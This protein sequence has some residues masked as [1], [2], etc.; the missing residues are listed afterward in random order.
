MPQSFLNNALHNAEVKTVLA[1]SHSIVECLCFV[2][3][4]VVV[5][6]VVA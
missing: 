5:V 3:V 4:V 6:V 1:F 2:I